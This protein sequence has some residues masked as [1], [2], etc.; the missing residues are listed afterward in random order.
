MTTVPLFYLKKKDESDGSDEFE[1][2]FRE[3]EIEL[4]GWLA[5]NRTVSYCFVALL[6]GQDESAQEVQDFKL[7]DQG[8]GT[9]PTGYY[10]K[11]LPN[12]IK[13]KNPIR[14]RFYG[15]E[16]GDDLIAVLILKGAG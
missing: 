16:S 8:I 14:V 7:L 2:E 1:I 15:T 12:I 13:T 9:P 4:V 10:V 5:G 11:F 3:G 6:I